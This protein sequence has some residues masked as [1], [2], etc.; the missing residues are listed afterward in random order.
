MVIGVDYYL[1]EKKYW[2]HGW[3]TIIPYSKGLSDYSFIYESGKRS[4][5]TGVND[6]LIG[7]LDLN[8]AEEVWFKNDGID[9]VGWINKGDKYID[10]SIY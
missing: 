8:E 10:K 7:H 6:E 3:A 9:I 5:I 4:K 2:V 1:Y